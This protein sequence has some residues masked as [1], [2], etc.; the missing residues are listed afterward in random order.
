[1]K[2]RFISTCIGLTDCTPPIS[3]KRTGDRPAFKKV[4]R[5]QN[6]PYYVTTGSTVLYFRQETVSVGK[7]KS[8]SSKSREYYSRMES[9]ILRIPNTK[10]AAIN[11]GCVGINWIF[12]KISSLFLHI[13]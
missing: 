11:V 7:I 1:M 9:M 3:L 2:R 12:R 5:H 6:A 4:P 10:A 8:D 13:K